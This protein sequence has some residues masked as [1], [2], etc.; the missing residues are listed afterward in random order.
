MDLIL[1]NPSSEAITVDVQ[2]R[3]ITATGMRI[4]TYTNFHIWNNTGGGVDY[5]SGPY[6]V[7]FP[8]GMTSTM[9]DLLITGDFIL[10]RDEQFL[11]TISNSLPDRVLLGNPRQTTV[12]IVDNDG[13]LISDITGSLYRQFQLPMSTSTSQDTVLMKMTGQHNLY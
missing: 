4:F 2:S 11:L 13:K 7:T 10:E 8:A 6:N 12:T 9:L 5:V 1:S 3:D